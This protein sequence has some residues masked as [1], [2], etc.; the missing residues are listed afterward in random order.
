[1][2][3]DNLINKGPS[4]RRVN[5]GPRKK[6]TPK[7]SN[8]RQLAAAKTFTERVEHYNLL[9]HLTQENRGRNIVQLLRVDANEAEATKRKLFCGKAG[10]KFMP[11]FE[12][13]A[14]RQAA[15]PD[16]PKQLVSRSLCVCINKEKT[17]LLLCRTKRYDRMSVCSAAS[18]ATQYKQKKMRMADRSEATFLGKVDHVPIT[19]GYM[20]HA[21]TTFW[22]VDGAPIGLIIGR[23]AQKTMR[24]SLDFS[25]DI[26]IFRSEKQVVTVPLWT[27]K[28]QDGRL[29][30]E[31]FTSKEEDDSGEYSTEETEQDFNTKEEWN[32]APHDYIVCPKEDLD[33]KGISFNDVLLDIAVE[34]MSTDAR[35]TL[36]QLLS[37]KPSI[38]AWDLN[39][40]CPTDVPSDTPSNSRITRQY[41]FL[42]A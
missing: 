8:A 22:V 9:S 25:K 2:N 40:L 12:K 21:S 24:A 5:N 41:V 29:L 30:S 23:P 26:A 18:S 28:K 32:G 4:L 16:D 7:K 31:E 15:V 6:K 39:E 13:K 1:M 19:V 27:N 10:R 37:E 33:D 11:A 38:V 34:R 42:Y 20:T 35:E 17:V 36:K 3:I 14:V